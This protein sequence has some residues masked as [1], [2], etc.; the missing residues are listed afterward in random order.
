MKY[1]LHLDIMKKVFIAI[2]LM[3]FTVSINA[4]QA[5]RMTESCTSIMV[6]RRRVPTGR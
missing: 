5:E 4:Q 3:A 6:G 1:Q 2:M